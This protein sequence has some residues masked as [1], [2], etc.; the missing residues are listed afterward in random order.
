MIVLTG[1]SS[2]SKG[3]TCIQLGAR[4]VIEKG[5]DLNVRNFLEFANHNA[6]I[7]IINHRYTSNT[8]CDTLSFATKTLLEKKPQSVTE[9]AELMKITDRQLR[10]LWHT[11]S[12]FSAKHVLTIFTFFNHAF[13][14]FT[15][16]H[17]GS[18]EEKMALQSTYNLNKLH[19]YFDTHKEI[20]SFILS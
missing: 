15:M 3:A 11:S 9:W 12:G 7:N 6:L 18:N 5:A 19:T 13:H 1:S 8:T 4:G 10:N 17:Y 14:Y 16:F 20:I 2:P